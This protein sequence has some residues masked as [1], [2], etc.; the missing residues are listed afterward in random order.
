M[1]D[2]HRSRR[3]DKNHRKSISDHRVRMMNHA[4]QLKIK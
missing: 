4:G 1:S 3:W 2:L